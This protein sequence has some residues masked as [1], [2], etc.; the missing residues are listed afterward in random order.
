MH[1]RA[2]NCSDSMIYILRIHRKTSIK[3]H[4][5]SVPIALGRGGGGG[6]G[7][8]KFIHITKNKNMEV[9][10]SEMRIPAFW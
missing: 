2:Q 7:Q 9:R 4:L 8:E 5:H 6:G 1:D 3:G 10:F